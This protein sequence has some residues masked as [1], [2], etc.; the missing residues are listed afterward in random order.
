MVN[1]TP[2]SLMASSAAARRVDISSGDRLCSRLTRRLA[3][4]LRLPAGVSS[5]S[6]NGLFL[7]CFQRIL[8]MSG[9]NRLASRACFRTP[10]GGATTLTLQDCH[11]RDVRAIPDYR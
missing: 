10:E 7:L 11:G 6:K 9:A 5:S 8:V 2:I 1:E 4:T 3:A